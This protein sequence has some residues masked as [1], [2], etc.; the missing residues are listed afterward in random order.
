[1][2]AFL[3]GLSMDYEVFILTRV[4]EEFD[5]GRDTR[6]SPRRGLGRTGRLVT[7]AALILFLA[8]ISLASAPL[9][10][11]SRS[12]PPVLASFLTPPSSARCSC[13]HWSCCSENGTG[14]CQV[15]SSAC[16]SS[17]HPARSP[18]SRQSKRRSYS[19]A[20][21]NFPGGRGAPRSTVVSVSTSFARTLNPWGVGRTRTRSLPSS[22]T[23]ASAASPDTS[24]LAP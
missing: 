14:G 2:F 3:F 12:S 23:N 10:G 24:A 6:R 18:P 5:A 15:A 11:M 8:F 22:L 17:N 19:T 20:T 7:S 1:M 9:T 21:R 16:F 13:R 4:R